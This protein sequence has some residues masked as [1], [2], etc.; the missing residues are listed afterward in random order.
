MRAVTIHKFGGV[1]QIELLDLPVPEI[2]ADE[3]LTQVKAA[4]VGNWDRTVRE[5][6]NGLGVAGLP[7]PVKLG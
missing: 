2:G 1:E 7:F 5:N 3:V 6:I 4:G